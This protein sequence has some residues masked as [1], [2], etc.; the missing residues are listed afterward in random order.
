MGEYRVHRF[1]H[2]A[3]MRL[4]IHTEITSVCIRKKIGLQ[5]GMR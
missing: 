4:Q 5:T 3:L 1:V 2:T